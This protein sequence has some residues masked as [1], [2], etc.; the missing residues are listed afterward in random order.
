[1]NNSVPMEDGVAGGSVPRDVTTTSAMSMEVACATSVG[2]VP[3]NPKGT[4]MMSTVACVASID[5]APGASKA[6]V[7]AGAGSVMSARDKVLTRGGIAVYSMLEDMR[8]DVDAE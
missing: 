2:V 5:D 4:D 6:L 3:G 1:M 8:E 7:A